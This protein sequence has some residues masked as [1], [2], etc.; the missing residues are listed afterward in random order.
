[1]AAQNRETTVKPKGKPRGRPF[2]PGNNANPG[3]RPKRGL[4]IVDNLRDVLEQTDE[5]GGKTKGQLLAEKYIELAMGGS[6]AAMEHIFA[7]FPGKPEQ[8]IK[9]SGDEASPLHIR[10]PPRGDAEPLR[11]R[12]SDRGKADTAPVT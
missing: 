12:H 1:M 11:V 5:E 10:V 6:V 8:G 9:L 2:P 7:R 4:S 3:G